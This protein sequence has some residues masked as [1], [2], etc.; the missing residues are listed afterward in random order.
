M[1]VSS[2]LCKSQ[3]REREREAEHKK[4]IS[5][6]LSFESLL[7]LLS[8]RLFFPSFRRKR[9]ESDE[10]DV[11]RMETLLCSR[12]HARCLHISLRSRACIRWHGERNYRWGRVD[13]RAESFKFQVSSWNTRGTYIVSPHDF[14]CRRIGFDDAFKVA[15]ISLLDVVGIEAR[16]QLKRHRGRI[17]KMQKE[18]GK[19]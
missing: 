6:Q 3:R 15:V 12:L 9:I 14:V 11:R 18:R 19:L 1:L 4:C 8:S 13:D 7:Y 17:W 5:S 10:I 16:S 2:A